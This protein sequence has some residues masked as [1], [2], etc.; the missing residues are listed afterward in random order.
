MLESGTLQIERFRPVL[1]FANEDREESPAL[2]DLVMRTLGYDRYFHPALTIE[3]DNFFGN[4][5]NYWAPRQMVSSMMLG[6]PSER[7][8]LASGLRRMEGKD[9]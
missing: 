9:D 8:V 6:I 1:Y 5:E 3:P 2:C 4:P 7:R